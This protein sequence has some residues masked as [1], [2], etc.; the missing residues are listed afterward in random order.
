LKFNRI[1]LSVTLMQGK[2]EVRSQKENQKRKTKPTLNGTDFKD[3]SKVS[4]KQFQILLTFSASI[5]AV[6]DLIGF[7]R[8]SSQPGCKKQRNSGAGIQKLEG[9]VTILRNEDRDYRR[10]FVH[11]FGKHCITGGGA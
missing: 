1:E 5:Q 6:D 4:Q 8:H 11:S 2:P 10:D 3:F 7:G 9:L